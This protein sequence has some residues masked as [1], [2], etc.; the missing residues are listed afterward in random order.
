LKRNPN[1][2]WTRKADEVDFLTSVPFPLP[3][4]VEI[5]LGYEYIHKDKNGRKAL[6][7]IRKALMGDSKVGGKDDDSNESHSDDLSLSAIA[8]SAR[9]SL[10]RS[11]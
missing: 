8:S 3:Y 4:A 1:P 10:F 2:R 5:E 7:C 9:L 6:S 11:L